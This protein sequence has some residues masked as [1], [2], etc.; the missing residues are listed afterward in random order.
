MT[1]VRL[2]DGVAADADELMSNFYHVADGDLL[3]RS[4]SFVPTS[5]AYD[6]GS[7]AY[8]WQQIHAN[9]VASSITFSSDVVFNAASVFSGEAVFSSVMTGS[10]SFLIAANIQADGV[11]GGSCGASYAYTTAAVMTTLTVNYIA[12]AT[13]SSSVLTL[14][15]GSYVC[16]FSY[17]TRMV[18]RFILWNNTASTTAV[19]GD[20]AQ[21]T[22][23]ALFHEFTLATSSA[24]V[25]KAT[26]SSPS[27]NTSTTLGA[28]C[29][30]GEPEMYGFMAV[31]RV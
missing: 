20:V 26:S 13:L 4:T 8:R 18:A 6:L 28:P 25:L 7:S 15:A 11:S 24:L 5:S 27:A 14:P 2:V 12:G 1:W 19:I 23:K 16:H 30:F 3:P 17:T 10:R 9:E 21:Q 29:S 22:S 31:Y